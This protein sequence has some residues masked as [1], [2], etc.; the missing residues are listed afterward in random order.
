[1]DGPVVDVNL[2]EDEML[3]LMLNGELSA[4]QMEKAMARYFRTSYSA[5][6]KQRMRS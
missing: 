2:T 4:E 1:M 6:K 5:W 3:T